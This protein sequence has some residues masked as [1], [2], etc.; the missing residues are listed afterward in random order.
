[1]SNHDEGVIKY[2]QSGFRFTPPLP[3]EEYITLEKYR[4]RLNRMELISAYDNGLGYGNISLRKDYSRFHQTDGPQFLIT[5]T[6][7]G[8]LR[9]LR[10]EHYTR[11]TDFDLD[12]FSVIAQGTIRASSETVTHAAIYQM[13]RDIGSVIH[14]HQN[15]I[16][17][18]MKRGD[19]PATGKW[20][21]YGTFEMAVAVKECI[22]DR[23]QGIIVMKGHEEG[24]IAYG[25]N[26]STVMGIIG[27][28]YKKYVAGSFTF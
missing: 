20:I 28:V 16:W 21:P 18:E 3:R 7:T 24:V 22:G 8:H 6:Q 27:K 2:D 25:P 5:G 10:G 26:L 17:K 15:K 9:D 23:T 11:V 12:A 14:I 19:Y 1:M 13:N 4:K